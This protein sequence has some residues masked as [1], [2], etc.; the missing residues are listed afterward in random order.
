MPPVRVSILAT[1]DS[2]V[3]PVSG[4]FE[5]LTWVGTLVADDEGPRDSPPFEVEIVGPAAGPMPRD[6]KSVV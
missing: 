2:L 5:V 1:P 6:R 4:M 3:Y